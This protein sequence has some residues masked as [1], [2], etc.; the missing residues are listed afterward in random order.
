MKLNLFLRIYFGIWLFIYCSS[1]G[2]RCP[3]NY[4][5]ADFIMKMLSDK[6]KSVNS[7]C[8]EFAVSKHSELIRNAISN[9]IYYVS[10]YT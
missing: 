9:E 5:S 7:V 3:E 10:S 8:D 6:N 4:N 2:F 1:V